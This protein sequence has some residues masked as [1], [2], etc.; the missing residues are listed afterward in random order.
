MP[1]ITAIADK[2]AGG[3][4]IVA[5]FMY[6]RPILKGK[7]KPNRA[8]WWIWTVVGFMLSASYFSSSKNHTVWIPVLYAAVPLFVA[9]LSIKYGKGG[10]TPFDRY[11]LLGA[12]LSML[13]WWILNSPLIALLI[14]LLIDFLGAL[15]TIRKVYYE[16]RSEDRAAWTWFFAGNTVNLFAVKSWKFTDASYPIYM[17]LVTGFIIV[18]MST[19]KRHEAKAN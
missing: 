6:L 14:N 16:P 1:D 18:L 3:I 19:E 10:W 17:F 11:C 15:P 4:S 7:L 13:L 8:T 9:I 5:F 2:V 12:G